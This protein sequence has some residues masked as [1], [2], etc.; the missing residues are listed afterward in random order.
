MKFQASS[1][2]SCTW[3]SGSSRRTLWAKRPQSARGPRCGLQ[4][5]VSHPKLHPNP[6]HKGILKVVCL[7]EFA[8]RHAPKSLRRIGQ[9]TVGIS[10]AGHKRAQKTPSVHAQCCSLRCS[11]PRNWTP[12]VPGSLPST[13]LAPARRPS[14]ASGSAP[15]SFGPRR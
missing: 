8:F 10:L 2:S 7:S 3:T 1:S 6:Q 5:C 9:A 13:Q 11:R 14:R 15:G 12:L 4:T